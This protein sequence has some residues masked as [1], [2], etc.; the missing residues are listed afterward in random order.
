MN[1]LVK[2]QLIRIV[3]E[4]GEEVLLDPV[5]TKA[6]LNDLCGNKY[7]REIN[8]ITLALKEGAAAELLNSRRNRTERFAIARLS[9]NLEESFGFPNQQTIW[10]LESIA[11]ALG[12]TIQDEPIDSVEKA[13][14]KAPE[15]KPLDLSKSQVSR[16]EE[17]KDEKKESVYTTPAN[18]RKVGK[19]RRIG[20]RLFGI[21]ALITLMLDLFDL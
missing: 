4:N 14:E 8:S 7:K 18:T 20:L 11:I 6:F 16:K 9:K 2:E 12:I 10:A 15:T 17:T 1:D 21:F 19:K 5:R 13:E 3:R